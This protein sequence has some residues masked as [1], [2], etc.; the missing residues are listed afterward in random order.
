MSTFVCF[1]CELLLL[2]LGLLINPSQ[3]I[4]DLIQVAFNE[5][6]WVS[7]SIYIIYI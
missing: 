5:M 3:T 7:H 6:H 4:V 1:C 2:N